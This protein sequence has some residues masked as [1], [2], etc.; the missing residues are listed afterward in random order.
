MAQSLRVDFN[1]RVVG[2]S[3]SQVI[4]MV[5]N[6]LGSVS[7]S[8]DRAYVLILLNKFM[9]NFLSSLVKRKGFNFSRQLL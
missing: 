2:G 6:V 5:V 9:A 8:F 4:S 3:R 1:C 7:D